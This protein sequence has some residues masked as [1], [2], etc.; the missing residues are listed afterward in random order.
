MIASR[1][2][3]VSE[4]VA[5]L[6]FRMK[7]PGIHDVDV[8]ALYPIMEVISRDAIFLGNRTEV[9]KMSNCIHIGMA[10]A[11]QL[12]FPHNAAHNFVSS[13]LQNKVTFSG[14]SGISDKTV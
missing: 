7:L 5:E 3:V 8:S 10:R 9:P 2:V 11:P 13:F 6:A 14:F 12:D 4:V 1:V